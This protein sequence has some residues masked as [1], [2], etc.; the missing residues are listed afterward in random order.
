MVL[1]V[2]FT[3]EKE[4]NTLGLIG[5]SKVLSRW[6]G[7]LR[8]KGWRVI[9][10]YTEGSSSTDRG[11]QQ[12]D[13]GSCCPAALCTVGLRNVSLLWLCDFCWSTAL[14]ALAFALASLRCHHGRKRRGQHSPQDGK[15]ATKLSLG[16]AITKLLLKIA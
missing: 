8:C 12:I 6:R 3:S 14:S 11:C 5:K 9:L 15:S 7:R 1:G 16:L 4:F 10:R 2:R 13:V